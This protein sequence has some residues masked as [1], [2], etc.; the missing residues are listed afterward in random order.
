MVICSID[1]FDVVYCFYKKSNKMKNLIIVLSVF[2]AVSTVATAQMSTKPSKES[3]QKTTY[4]C[5][6]HPNE[7]SMAAGKCPKC[8]MELVKTT[9]TQLN[10]SVKGSQTSTIIEAKYICKMDGSTS[11]K[12]G[13]CP[14]CGMGMTKNEAPKAAYACPM[15]PT[16]TGKKGDK[17]SKCGMDLAKVEEDKNK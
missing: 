7:M 12:P 16:V 6:M 10:T 11:D 13:K 1:Y 2:L 5:P 9:K 15:H 14:K 4:V 17:C 3:T 8:G